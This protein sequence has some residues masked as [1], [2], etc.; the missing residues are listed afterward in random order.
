[1]PT[2]TKQAQ[3]E[4]N[5]QQAE[6][7]E[8]QSTP[9][10]VA[11]TFKEKIK[12]ILVTGKCRKFSDIRIKNVKIEEEDNYTRVT[13]VVMP[14]L[15]C[16]RT[17]DEGEVV[18]TTTN[19]IFTSTFAL[20]GMLKEDEE[21]SW[22]AESLSAN[23]QAINLIMN[24]GTIDII[25]QTV[26]AGEPY[27]NPFTTKD[28]VEDITFENDTIV[29]HIIGFKYGKTGARFADTLAVKMMGF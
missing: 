20:A 29:N 14:P 12:N 17:N 9:A 3:V 23:P 22:L 1:M 13:F 8:A 10:N 2:T 7:K 25:Q 27:R 21:K 6:A 24:G 16:F 28:D 26:Q 4:Q 19:N 18:A 11:L 15:P 5:V